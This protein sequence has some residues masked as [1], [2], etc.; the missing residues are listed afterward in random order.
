MPRHRSK[1][2]CFTLNHPTQEESEFLYTLIQD[3]TMPSPLKLTYLVFGREVASTSTPHFQGYL[4]S[5]QKTSLSTMKKFLSRAHWEK[6]KG[7]PKQASE[8][9]KKDLDFVESGVLSKGQGYRSDLQEIKKDISQGLTEKEIADKYF[10]KWVVY[11]RS[12]QRYAALCAQ[13]RAW[14]T[15][16]HVYWG[17]TGT[18]KTR[19]VMDQIMDSPFWSPGDYKWFDGYEGQPIVILDDYRGEYQLQ[20][21]LKL[22]DRYPMQVPVKGGFTTWCPKKVY[23]TS[24]VHPNDWYKEADRYSVSALFRRLHL[25]EAVFDPLY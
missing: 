16:V 13:D 12:F 23:I 9:C 1:R 14:Q 5:S 17:K 18:G 21:L 19:F 25:I 11:R 7:S 8:Y 20:M 6:A 15:I 2:W 24:N 3:L 22:L 10:E 4:E